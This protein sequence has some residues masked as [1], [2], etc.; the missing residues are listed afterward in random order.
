[1]IE[2]QKS[3]VGH[4]LMRVRIRK[5]IFCMLQEAAEEE[6]MRSGEHVTVSDLV[7]VACYN[8]LLINE[9]LRRLEDAPPLEID[10]AVLIITQPML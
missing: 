4:H 6:T 1:M 9:S 3:L 10:D 8:Y 7:R 5:S 2:S